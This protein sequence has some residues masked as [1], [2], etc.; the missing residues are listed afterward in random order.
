MMGENAYRHYVEHLRAHHPEA[1]VP[2]E[3]EFWRA[4]WAE[5]GANPGARCC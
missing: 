4:T 1:P 3:R 2:T 5:Q